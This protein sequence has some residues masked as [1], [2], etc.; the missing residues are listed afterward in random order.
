MKKSATT[1]NAIMAE[2]NEHAAYGGGLPSKTNTGGMTLY[3]GDKTNY[4]GA[5]F[6]ITMKY[7]ARGTWKTLD[8][9][10]KFKWHRTD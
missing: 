6:P 1:S 5:S 10:T 2:G 4:I 9:D 8:I 3:S 7:Y